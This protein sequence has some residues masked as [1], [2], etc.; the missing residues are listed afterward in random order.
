M[1]AVKLLIFNWFVL[2]YSCFPV[3]GSSLLYSKMNQLYVYISRQS[4]QSHSRVRLFA[5]PWP[6]AH[7]ASCPSPTPGACSNS[8]QSSRGSY[9]TISSSSFPFFSCLQSFPASGSFP[10]SQFFTSGGQS[11]WGSASV[12]PMHEYSGLI[13]FGMDRLALHAVLCIPSL[14]NFLPIQVTTVY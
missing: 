11:I 14:L 2:E 7:Q 3:L 8:C 6:A 4:V 1:A 12:L 10:M 13:S 9:P 5:T